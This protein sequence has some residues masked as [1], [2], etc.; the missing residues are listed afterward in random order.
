MLDKLKFNNDGLITVVVQD[1]L[2]GDVLMQAY[3]NM[4][5][6][7]LT[8]KTGYAHY[9]SRSRQKIWKKG[10]TSNNVQKICSIYVDCDCDSILYKVEQTGVACHTGNK[11]C[12]YTLL[13]NKTNKADYRSIFSTL[14]IIN[15]RVANPPEKSYTNYLLQKGV[16]KICKKIGEEATETVI[17]AIKNDN[18]ET[19]M[20]ISDLIYHVLVLMVNQGISMQEVLDECARRENLLPED[21]FFKNNK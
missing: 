12:F 15:D 1:N 13:D 2:T 16:E 20:E 11:N 3:A 18:V 19:V 6:L 10:E 17:S 9:F 7:E 14:D 4:E 21:K 5:A 8:L